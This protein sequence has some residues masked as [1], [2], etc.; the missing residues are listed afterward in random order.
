MVHLEV[1]NDGQTAL[2]GS[3][4]EQ[5]GG[6]VCHC[7]SGSLSEM[8]GAL[9]PG[10]SSFSMV[11]GS[12]TPVQVQAPATAQ[13]ISVCPA[14]HV[15]LHSQ[16]CAANALR[17]SLYTWCNCNCFKERVQSLRPWM[18]TVCEENIFKQTSSLI[19]SC[20][21]AVCG[22]PK[23]YPLDMTFMCAV[24]ACMSI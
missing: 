11:S 8:S 6:Y 15:C 23:P 12:S 16:N 2:A 21:I 17:C 4:L 10:S 9:S 22:C 19:T 24:D 20:A 7:R 5:T 14:L 3:A 1:G 13:G 18:R